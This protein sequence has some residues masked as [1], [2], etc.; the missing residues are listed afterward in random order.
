MRESWEENERKIS[1]VTVSFYRSFRNVSSRA[2]DDQIIVYLL[3]K[4]FRHSGTPFSQ[5]SILEHVHCKQTI[6][7]ELFLELSDIFVD[8]KNVENLAF[9][10]VFLKFSTS[11]FV[12]VEFMNK[13][14]QIPAVNDVVA[15]HGQSLVERLL[16]VRYIHSLAWK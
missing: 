2:S 16:R 3:G 5:I 9:L 6:L 4:S 10:N 8:Y 7:R 13:N 12:Q 1:I 11:V 14:E 15:M